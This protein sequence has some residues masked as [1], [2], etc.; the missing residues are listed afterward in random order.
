MSKR[1][2]VLWQAV[3]ALF[4]GGFTTYSL[5]YCTQPLL[6]IFS[7][8]FNVSPTVASLSLS[9]AIAGVI[10]GM[11]ITPKL[12]KRWGRKRVMSVALASAAILEGAAA[13]SPYY[14]LFLVVR[15]LQGLV[16]AG[17]P[18]NA[19]AYVMEEFPPHQAG[20]IMGL[21]ISGTA[22]GG[23][24]GRLAAG[25]LTA[26][27][28]WQV[29]MLVL[30]ACGAFAAIWFIFSLPGS[31]NQGGQGGETL[32]LLESLQRAVTE[33]QLLYLYLCGFLI[34]GAFVTLFNYMSYLLMAD[35][36]GL[37]TADIGTLFLLNAIGTVIAPLAGRLTALYSHA[38]VLAGG[39]V[40]MLLGCLVTLAATFG[41]KVVGMIVFSGAFAAN[42]ATISGWV[43]RCATFDKAQA[44]AWYLTFYYAGSVV[45]GTAGGLFW[46]LYGW[47]G[48]IAMIAVL[49][50]VA[51]AIV[52]RE[53]TWRT[54]DNRTVHLP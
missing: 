26:W 12:S 40:L 13:L 14:E 33:R 23:M 6:P 27:Y 15:S 25:W 49:L 39:I 31:Q 41:I 21:Y 32:G 47:S 46:S 52:M 45:A 24:M 38:K 53:P 43:G 17:F 54:A 7:A 16:L 9:V 37:S 44:S 22:V 20:T 5:L 29:A 50:L 18:A 36:Y 19:M 48:V 42:H 34:M 2:I 3:L 1:T 30:A 10:L 4:L 8:Y 28:S 51:L 11:L 35:P